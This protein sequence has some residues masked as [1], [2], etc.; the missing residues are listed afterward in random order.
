[1]IR[2][3]IQLLSYIDEPQTPGGSVPFIVVRVWAVP[4]GGFQ[5]STDHGTGLNNDDAHH[6][7]GYQI[8]QI[9]AVME[10]GMCLHKYESQSQPMISIRTK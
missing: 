4:V 3:V 8:A 10:F 5:L 9:L 7:T 2:V 1:M 6:G